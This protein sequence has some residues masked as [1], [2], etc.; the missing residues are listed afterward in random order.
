MADLKGYQRIGQY[1]GDD[2]YEYRGTN[3]RKTRF[4]AVSARRSIPDGL[5]MAEDNNSVVDLK[6]ILREKDSMTFGPGC[7]TGY[8]Y[9]KEKPED[10]HMGINI[11]RYVERDNATHLPKYG[12]RV[13]K[14][15]LGMRELEGDTV[16]EVREKI[17]GWK[18][19]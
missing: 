12:A 9:R 3:K 2:L 11:G 1:K 17:E 15:K 18:K 14:E 6:I 16:E 13:Y 19:T 8:P 5:V 7:L 10:T 4:I